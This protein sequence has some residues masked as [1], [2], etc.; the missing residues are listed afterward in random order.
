MQLTSGFISYQTILWTCFPTKHHPEQTPINS[1]VR[2]CSLKRNCGKQIESISTSEKET[3]VQGAW[4]LWPTMPPCPFQ[5]T[6]WNPGILEAH[7]T[8]AVLTQLL[9]WQIN[10]ARAWQG[11]F[12]NIA[13][14][15]TGL[16]RA[17]GPQGLPPWPL[18]QGQWNQSKACPAHVW[19]LK[20]L[21]LTEMRSDVNWADTHVLLF[22]TKTE[23]V[24]LLCPLWENLLHESAVHQPRSS[25]VGWDKRGRGLLEPALLRLKAHFQGELRDPH[26][27]AWAGI[28]VPAD[29][30]T[31]CLFTESWWCFLSCLN[32]WF[33]K[34]KN[35]LKKKSHWKYEILV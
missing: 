35:Y 10:W 17:L 21:L 22:W 2:A 16:H 24:S 18:E 25:S 34:L 8:K 19:F 11:I 33:L 28:S 29:L 1:W 30:Q 7:R 5:T 32:K 14:L 23:H 4:I 9:L 3:M 26:I 12:I 31:C 20:R 27:I 6:L 15:H 13:W